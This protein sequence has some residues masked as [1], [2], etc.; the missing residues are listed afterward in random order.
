MLNPP[1]QILFKESFPFNHWY[2]IFPLS[3]G[4]FAYLV[5]LSCLFINRVVL[6]GISSGAWL[7]LT[8]LELGYF[9]QVD[10]CY[11]RVD[12]KLLPYRP[13]LEVEF[14]ASIM[15]TPSSSQSNHQPNVMVDS[16][17]NQQWSTYVHLL[18][19]LLDFLGHING[20]QPPPTASC[21]KKLAIWDS[22]NCCARGVISQSVANDI[23]MELQH[24]TTVQTMWAHLQAVAK[25]R[26]LSQGSPLYRRASY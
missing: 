16:T 7:S 3:L 13:L 17:N 15:V 25:P 5:A 12:S 26:S 19:D 4:T 21:N 11:S 10:I 22:S 20:T 6:A 18:L 9:R 1:L 24:L 2:F 14:L 23:H 8:F